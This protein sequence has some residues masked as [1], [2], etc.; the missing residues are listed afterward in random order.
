[1]ENTADIDYI[2]KFTLLDIEIPGEE[3]PQ[4][5]LEEEKL[6][7]KANRVEQETLKEA[8][9]D[10]EVSEDS[11]VFVT[12]AEIVGEH[13]DEVFY[14]EGPPTEALKQKD[15]GVERMRSR[16]ESQRS[17]KDGGLALFESEETTLTPIFISPGPPKII[18]PILLEEPTAMSFM[19]S[20]LYEDAVGEKRRSDEECSEA[21]SVASEKSYKRRL[22]DSDEA[23]G[24]LEKFR[25]KDETPAM[26]IQSESVGDKT[27]GRMVWSQ[28]KF[29][30]TGCL[31][32]AAKDEEE[33]EMTKNDEMK[34][35]GMPEM[36]EEKWERPT[37]TEEKQSSVMAHDEALAELPEESHQESKSEDHAESKQEQQAVEPSAETPLMKIK[38]GKISQCRDETIAGQSVTETEA[39]CET[40]S[41]AE[42]KQIVVTPDTT[43]LI[44]AE[45]RE[46]PPACPEPTH[47]TETTERSLSAEEASVESKMAAADEKPPPEAVA[48]MKENGDATPTTLT[49]SKASSEVSVHEDKQSA[50]E[51]AASLEVITDCERTV[52]TVEEMMEKATPEEEIQ[53]QDKIDLQEDTEAKLLVPEAVGH[54]THLTEASSEESK[55]SAADQ[56]LGG[57][58]ETSGEIT[59]PA[60][61]KE[62][63]LES[64]SKHNQM[65]QENTT[66]CENVKQTA[67]PTS[68]ISTE[69]TGTSVQDVVNVGDEL[70]LLVPKGQ[71]VEMDIQ[72]D[73]WSEDIIKGTVSTPELD[74]S[75]EVHAP[76]LQVE[77]EPVVAV[78]EEELTSNEL[79]LKP[80]T[81]A[82]VE[83]ARTEDLEPH[84][85]KLVLPP[86]RS[87]APQEDLSEFRGDDVH[88]E[89]SEENID[90]LSPLR[91]FTPQEDLSE[92]QGDDAYLEESEEKTESQEREGKPEISLLKVDEAPDLDLHREDVEQ[93][94]EQRET[95]LETREETVEDLG[96][97]VIDEKDTKGLLESEI[98]SEKEEDESRWRPDEKMETDVEKD[99]L[100]EADY[101]IIDAE[102]TSQARV[103]AELE[104]MDWFCNTC[105]CLLSED[106]CKS[107]E[108]QGHQVCSVDKAYEDVKVSERGWTIACY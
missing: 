97:E 78:K 59:H 54:Q 91:S 13:L 52:Q 77:E 8:T 106:E 53:I 23:D 21:E 10:S 29:E 72:I 27:K 44:L 64:T 79:D 76:E 93:I 75:S 49:E 108:H 104:G 17:M 62:T 100:D 90:V 6:P 18:D 103:A 47:L 65:W 74:I 35:Q 19:Y 83:E 95:V 86:L 94:K 98:Q 16:R 22:S 41:E 26:D 84:E 11:F 32:R 42:S 60:K 45:S 80:L 48:E 69:D 34:T 58:T 92:F 61:T 101:E 36:T 39:P 15:K 87:F 71:A 7:A 50:S 12:D 9:K 55:A 99:E 85:H 73:Q 102:E 4:L 82:P 38:V 31:I 105:G 2:E 81:P 24:Y 70:I 20:D 33:T 89:E 14:G 66:E 107:A 25:L 28:S 5:Q 68:R 30:M 67:E 43:A 1:M 56:E 57:K 96:Y 40:Q 63:D 88:A 37:G 3:A 46:D 51:D